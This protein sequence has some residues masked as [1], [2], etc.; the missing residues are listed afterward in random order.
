[1]TLGNSG[2]LCVDRVGSFRR[3]AQ[4]R[5]SNIE[6]STAAL[7]LLPSL[8]SPVSLLAAKC[9]LLPK[10][11]LVAHGVPG[12]LSR[13]LQ[14]HRKPLMEQTSVT[15]SSKIFQELDAYPRSCPIT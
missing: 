9:T 5:P 7:A 11:R 12:E 4:R 13:G 1:M 8:F 15:L 6:A 10:N 14:I 2:K 3:N